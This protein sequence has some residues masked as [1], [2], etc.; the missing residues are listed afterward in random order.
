MNLRSGLTAWRYKVNLCLIMVLITTLVLG[1]ASPAEPTVVPTATRAVRTPKPTFTPVPEPTEGAPTEAPTTVPAATQVSEASATP[2]ATEEAPPATEAPTNTPEIP[3][4]TEEPEPTSAPPDEPLR[5]RSPEYGMQ[6][7]L[8]YRPEVGSRDVQ[9]VKNAGFEWVKQGVG[10]RDVEPTKGSYNWE[11]LD[12]IVQWCEE[13]ELK[14]L[15]RVDHQPAW[16]R[17]ECAGDN[18]QGPPS[19]L[20]NFADFLKALVSRYRGKVKAYQI[21]NEPNLTRE[22]CNQPPNASEY[23]ALLATAYQVIKAADPGAMVIS[24]GLTSTTEISARARAD[25][26]YLREMYEAGAKPYFDVLGVHGAG[27]KAPPEMDPAEVARD[28]ALTNNDPSSEELK[29]A[30]CFRHVEDMRAIMVEYGDADKQIAILEMGWT[31]DP[32]PDSP[33]FWHRVENEQV[34]ADY[35]VRAYQYAKENWSP[36]IGLMSLIYIAKHEWTENDEQ[37]WWSIT[38]PGWPEFKPRPAYDAL[39]NMPK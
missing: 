37:Y 3:T 12:R 28:P 24:A 35:L 36:W 14:L 34:Q 1:C 20:G 16:A 6:A 18:E 26:V 39:K 23:V 21:W 31:V 2:P 15:L 5:M 29:R 27:Y 10:W 38:Y 32:R 25:V 9:L 4:P 33:Y 30:Y 17:N 22:W 19:N 8:W 13:Q 11:P 7:F